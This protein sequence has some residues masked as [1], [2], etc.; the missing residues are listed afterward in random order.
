MA[1]T[2]SHNGEGNKNQ[3]QT[4][5]YATAEKAFQEVVR[6]SKTDDRWIQ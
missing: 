3:E 4:L 2:A 5:N 6:D 1:N